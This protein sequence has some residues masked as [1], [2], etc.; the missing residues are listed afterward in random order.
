MAYDH[1]EQEQLDS[2]KAWW[3]RYG[4]LLTWALIAA[5]AL[6]TAWAGWNYY[7]RNQSVQAGQLY[8][9]LQKAVTEKDNA[10]IQRAAIDIQEKFSRTAYAQMAG[11]T[12]AKSAFD[13]NDLKTAATRL[14]WIVDNGIDDEYKAIAKL[15]LSGIYLDQ[16]AYD[17][18]L[19]I[20][21]GKFPDAFTGV[22]ADRKGDL[23]IAQNKPVEARAAYRTALEK[24]AAKNPGRQLIQLKLDA[25]G[26]IG[27]IGGTATEKG[28]A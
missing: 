18:G 16:K 12:A 3:S 26:G 10:K 20:L 25:I 7:V 6:Y 27:G 19:K 4:N 28:P 13:A 8:E 1:G 21:A 22:V 14:Q 5:L 9:A 17:Q 15:R 23:L 24:M 11:L 2:M